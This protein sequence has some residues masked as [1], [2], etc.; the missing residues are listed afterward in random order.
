MTVF[1]GAPALKVW[2]KHPDSAIVGIK[3]MAGKT[4]GVRFV[5]ALSFAL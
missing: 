2:R 5:M 3:R 1:S 4:L